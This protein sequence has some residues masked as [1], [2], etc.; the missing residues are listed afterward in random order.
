LLALNAGVTAGAVA[1]VVS[2]F[3]DVETNGINMSGPF[4]VN[5]NIKPD[6]AGSGGQNQLALAAGIAVIVAVLGFVVAR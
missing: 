2:K 6:L 3:N 4:G 1:L 5:V